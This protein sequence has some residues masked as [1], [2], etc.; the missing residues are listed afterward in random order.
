MHRVLAALTV[1]T[2]GLILLAGLSLAE[3][4][5]I[6]KRDGTIAKPG[7]E[8]PPNRQPLGEVESGNRSTF[9]TPPPPNRLTPAPVLPFN[10]NRALSP[11]PAP[12]YQPSPQGTGRFGR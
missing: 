11:T 12:P 3:N 8:G 7:T 5:A 2:A 4:D 6:H 9:G 10:P 1:G